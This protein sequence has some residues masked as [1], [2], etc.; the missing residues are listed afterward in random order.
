M[1]WYLVGAL[2]FC[3]LVSFVIALCFLSDPEGRGGTQGLGALAISVVFGLGFAGG[4]ISKLM[5]WL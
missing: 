2:A 3:A 4:V 5:A 1:S